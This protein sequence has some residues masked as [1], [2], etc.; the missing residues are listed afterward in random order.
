MT[1]FE[2]AFPE[3]VG[4][5][6]PPVV[7]PVVHHDEDAGASRYS[8]R[9]MT[10]PTR[11]VNGAIPVV[12]GMKGERFP[13]VYVRASEQRKGAVR[14]VLDADGPARR[15]GQRSADPAAAWIDGLASNEK[16]PSTPTRPACYEDT[17]LLTG[18]YVGTLQEAL[19]TACTIYLAGIAGAGPTPNSQELTGPNHLAV[20]R[21]AT[22]SAP[23]RRPRSWLPQRI[24]LRCGLFPRCPGRS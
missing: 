11:S 4:G 6:L 18:R 9:A 23:A 15:G 2:C 24:R 1:A 22:G 21:S 17:V 3:P 14:L 10:C 13:G 16:S 7:P 8:G 19:D 5:L 20:R 12:F